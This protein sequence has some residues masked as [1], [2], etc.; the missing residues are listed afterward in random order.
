MAD[1][2][3]ESRVEEI[4][5][6]TI[7]GTE[8]TEYPQS[9][10]EQLLIELKAVIE[11]GGGGGGT[12]N[13]NLL[14]NKP[15]IAG[16]EL[17]G[18]KSLSDLGITQE[19]KKVMDMLAGQFDPTETYEEGKIVVYNKTLYMFTTDHSAGEFNPLEVE[20]TDVDRL[21]AGV[22]NVIPTD[23]SDLDDDSTHRTVT[24][25]EKSEWNSK[26]SN[27]NLTLTPDAVVSDRDVTDGSGN[28]LSVVADSVSTPKT[29][30]G[31]PVIVE[32]ALESNADGL[33]AQI[34]PIQS[35]TGDPSPENIRPISG[36]TEVNLGRSG[37]NLVNPTNMGHGVRDN[38]TGAIVSQSDT[39][40]SVTVPVPV[41]G[42]T[43]YTVSK[44]DVAAGSGATRIFFYDANGGFLSTIVQNPFTTPNDARFVAFQTG[45]GDGNL[46]YWQIEEG[47][48]A[49]PYEPYK[50]VTLTI[51]LGQTVYGGT[52]DVK[53][54]VGTITHKLITLDGNAYTNYS[55]ANRWESSTN[56]QKYMGRTDTNVGNKKPINATSDIVA[57]SDKFRSMPENQREIAGSITASMVLDNALYLNFGEA[58]GLDTTEKQLAWLAQNPVQVC[59][60]L[61]TPTTIQLTANDL[62]L[63]MGYNRI[64][65][66]SGDITLTYKA[67]AVQ[68]LQT[69]KADN[70]D[71]VDYIEN[72]NK[73]SRAYSANQFMLWK[74]D[75]YKVTT[76]IASGATITA[77]TNVTKTTIGAVLTA[78]LNA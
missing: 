65:S 8:Y 38:T 49:T 56:W 18:N 62:A 40:A 57:I 53:T 6:A 33:V 26:Q 69:D 43:A 19:I 31:N 15:E 21:L 47:S 58:S 64:T 70:A 7:D 27:V 73:A 39:A 23:L 14:I 24:D 77:G 5:V 63:L 13:Y 11:A 30:T 51:S 50:G 29:A 46:E 45:I 61:A 1:I 55:F 37:K 72:G 17:S 4:L 34:V 28:T 2:Y 9:R 54:G 36:R 68:D 60:E 16:V 74:G 59:Y 48:T 32:D 76:S 71:I 78:L 44:N 25:T 75:L 12:T 67:N 10:I 66:D 3:P 20:Q 41:A 22:Y 52:L 35:G 42:G